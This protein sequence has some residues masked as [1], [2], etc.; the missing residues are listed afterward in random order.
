MTP[1]ANRQSCSRCRQSGH[2]KRS[3]DCPKRRQLKKAASKGGKAT[4]KLAPTAKQV[5]ASK[6]NGGKGGK[7]IDMR[8]TELFADLEEAPE[9]ALERVVWCQGILSK[10]TVGFLKGNIPKHVLDETRRLIDSI[11]KAV[12]R[13]RLWQAEQIVLNGEMKKKP[14]A[15]GR[16]TES[17][18]PSE[19]PIR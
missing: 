4:A 2:N 12:P 15:A 14:K 7:P 3:K 13:E 19:G 8:H 17:A 11:V 16:R 9:D 5:E 10:L 6:L 18:R 1:K